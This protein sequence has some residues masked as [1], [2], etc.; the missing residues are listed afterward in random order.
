M[1]LNFV[2]SLSCTAFFHGVFPTRTAFT[3]AGFHNLKIL[4]NSNSFLMHSV[5]QLI[6][7]VQNVQVS[8]RQVGIKMTQHPETSGDAISTTA[9]HQK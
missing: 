4:I 6:N 8:P 9:G 7:K 5:L 1:L 3:Q 2:V